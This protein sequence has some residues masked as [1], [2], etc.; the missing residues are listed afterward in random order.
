M[1]NIVLEHFHG[2]AS[3]VPV[4]QTAC[5]LRITG[6]NVAIISQWLDPAE[7][8]RHIAWARDTY[9]ALRRSW[10]DALPELPRRR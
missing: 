6:F 10:R 7:N 5:A 2:A 4:D 3:R 9:A 1:S 8:N